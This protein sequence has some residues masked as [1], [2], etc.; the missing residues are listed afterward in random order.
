MHE[1]R[2]TIERARRA[3]APASSPVRVPDADVPL[4]ALAAATSA[5]TA[6]PPPVRK[7]P[8][9][10][11][12]L[13]L[14]IGLAVAAGV[15][16]AG[17]FDYLVTCRVSLTP[18][19]FAGSAEDLR[20]E[21]LT[22]CLESERGKTSGG[23]ELRSCAVS[24]EPQ[25]L[26]LSS[27]VSD[28]AA[29]ALGA[30]A[31]VERFI[32]GVRERVRGRREEPGEAERVLAAQVE[33]FEK[34]LSRSDSAVKAAVAALPQDDPR[35][36]RDALLSKWSGVQTEFDESRSELEQARLMLSQLESQAIPERAVVSDEA[37]RRAIEA[38]DALQQD[39]SELGVNLSELRG[40]L[41]AA[42]R[43]ATQPMEK[44]QA[45]CD[46]LVAACA[47]ETDGL[48]PS[49]RE[50]LLDMRNS[51]KRYIAQFEPFREVWQTRF[52]HIQRREID[53]ESAAM[54]D[55]YGEIRKSLSDFL[56]QAARSLSEARDVLSQLAA[57]QT[58]SAVF[59]QAHA[60]VARAFHEMQT[61]H[62]RFEFS[63]SEVEAANNFRLEAAFRAARGLHR[64]CR[65]R[66]DLIEKRLEVEAVEAAQIELEQ[67]RKTASSS[68][69]RAR[70]AA[71]ATVDELVAL[72]SELNLTVAQA[73]SFQAALTEL[74]AARGGFRSTETA[75]A[76]TVESLEELK[77]ARLAEP[78]DPGVR[79][80]SCEVGERPENLRQR[81]QVGGISG[82]LALLLVL[83]CQWWVTRRMGV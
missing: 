3:A 26:V 61:A 37:R 12:L 49:A 5:R 32:D 24:M 9:P 30:S 25:S 19:R 42:R 64:R 68:V 51:S 57:A 17:G 22:L 10:S 45:S 75:I 82:G 69:E 8:R 7:A 54:L 79:L 16:W 77:S 46:A 83:G 38:H 21:L 52:E 66:L 59:H 58:D 27:L 36:N 18:H 13:S 80:A 53:P 39:L 1:S 71:D 76:A 62:H 33:A 56:F 48:L 70:E 11:I 43:K 4:E 72:Q 74:E 65:Q 35:V 29:G 40:H 2:E 15:T 73:E 78:E 14:V 60:R 67:K 28:R 50:M 34:L 41:L 31:V 55:E 81:L 6:S 44:L 20:R 63:A 47:T 23:D